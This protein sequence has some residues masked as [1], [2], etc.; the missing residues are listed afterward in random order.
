MGNRLISLGIIVTSLAVTAVSRSSSSTEASETVPGLIG[1]HIGCWHASFQHGVK[2]WGQA[3]HIQP[4]FERSAL[5]VDVTL[6]A[7]LDR[8]FTPSLTAVGTYTAA[9]PGAKVWIPSSFSTVTLLFV[10]QC[11]VA[12]KQFPTPSLAA[13]GRRV[14]NKHQWLFF[15]IAAQAYLMSKDL[16]PED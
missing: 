7:A 10:P 12:L 3:W 6:S 16:A 11:L 8:C 13:S 9:D 5:A 14:Y 1:F 15:A 4:G 2:E